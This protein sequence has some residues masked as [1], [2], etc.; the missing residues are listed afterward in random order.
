MELTNFA[1]QEVKVNY[2]IFNI[3]FNL[4]PL[5]IFE[6]LVNYKTEHGEYLEI[7]TN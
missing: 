3:I 4:L 2:T 6:H 7:E 5:K 1:Y